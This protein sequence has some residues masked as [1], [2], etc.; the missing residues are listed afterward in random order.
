MINLA[1]SFNP[2]FESNFLKINEKI[3][4]MEL[5]FLAYNKIFQGKSTPFPFRK[6]LSLSLHISRS[7]ITECNSHQDMFIQEKLVPIKKDCR[8]KSFGFHLCG[9]RCEN[10]GVLG[11]S[12]HYT[13]SQEKEKMQLNS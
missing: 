5:G 6:D 9:D 1:C 8:I 10:I 2:A 3:N 12:S 11:F 7:P 4:L 13:S